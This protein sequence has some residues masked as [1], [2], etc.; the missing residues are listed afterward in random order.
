MRAIAVVG[1][2]ATVT[3]L[4]TPLGADGPDTAAVK[5]EVVDAR[6]VAARIPDYRFT[7]IEATFET[8]DAD[9]RELF[10]VFPAGRAD[11]P[12]LKT[13]MAVLKARYPEGFTEG[14][15]APTME[16]VFSV[17]KGGV[18]L[19]DG[20]GAVAECSLVSLKPKKVK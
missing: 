2:F 4:A 16:A 12:H 15:T 10:V 13:L 1:V 19:H 14:L 5:P 17:P 8:L 9:R 7:V 20:K 18:G 6:L 11:T 3:A